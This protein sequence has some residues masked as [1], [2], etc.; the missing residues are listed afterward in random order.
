MRLLKSEDGVSLIEA[1]IAMAVLTIGAVGMGQAFLYG[2]QSA[3]TS[4]NELVAT[5]KA[6]EAI[7]SVFSA[8]DA[9]T[10]TWAQLRN[11]AKGGIF[12]DG[13]RK[14]N[15]AGADG[16]INT[17][18]AGETVETVVFPGRDQTLGTADDQRQSLDGFS[19][20]IKIIDLS[21]ELRSV[22]VIITYPYGTGTRTFSLTSY[23]SSW[24]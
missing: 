14:M 9:H 13:A 19:R 10:I 6:A 20:E 18:D 22:T 4:P 12:L 23:I 2:M 3:A 11:T 8:R 16:I 17:G 24:A 7:E 5:Q 15:T 1:V 21:N